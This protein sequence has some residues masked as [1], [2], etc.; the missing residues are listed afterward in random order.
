V[1]AAVEQHAQHPIARAITAHARAGGIAI[2][3]AREFA[4]RPG[5][6]AGAIVE[7]RTVRIGSAAYLAELGVDLSGAAESTGRLAAAG[8]TV[9]FVSVDARWIGTIAV[10]DGVRPG[11]EEALDE[12]RRLGISTAMLTGDQPRTAQ[13][14]AEA[15]GISDVLAAMSPQDKA[16]EVQRRQAA[17]RRIAFVGDGINDAPA[18]AAAEV[19]I[20]IA[21]ATDV[22]AGAAD[23]TIL[24]DDLRRIPQAIR[25]ARRTVRI[26]KQNL[27]W[28]FF[29]NVLAIPL[30]A[31]GAVPPGY[32]AAAMMV[33]SISVVLN[34][35]RLRE[36]QPLGPLVPPAVVS[37]C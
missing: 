13:A 22:A 2:P 10:E 7:E 19:G 20:T 11:A 31:L 35:L 14:I 18:L 33:S 36:P 12:L 21:S 24:H 29:Y 4:N 37:A 5:R 3:T 16:A 28:A 34:S 25:Q 27:F 8:K 17:G 15:L 9:V 30:A 1:A 26:I 32:A 6:G 23:I